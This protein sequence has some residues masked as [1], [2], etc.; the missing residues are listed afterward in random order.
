MV[1]RRGSSHRFCANAFRERDHEWCRWRV[2]SPDRKRDPSMGPCPTSPALGRQYH[3]RSRRRKKRSR[4]RMGVGSGDWDRPKRCGAIFYGTFHC[5]VASDFLVVGLQSERGCC[6]TGVQ[7][8][9]P[10]VSYELDATISRRMRH[11]GMT[12]GFAFLFFFFFLLRG[13]GFFFFLLFF[14]RAT[15]PTSLYRAV[16]KQAC[17]IAFSFSFFFLCSYR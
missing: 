7:H 8:A 16:F 9:R 6:R 11:G 2:S 4:R 5:R 3:H 13:N 17:L 15:L 12:P 10:V 14:A 1:T